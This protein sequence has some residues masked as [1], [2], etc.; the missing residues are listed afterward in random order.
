VPE[1]SNPESSASAKAANDYV[2]NLGEKNPFTGLSREQLSTIANDESGSFTT[3]EKY[4]AYRQA[5]DEEQKWR[6]EVVA[7]AMQEYEDTGKL[8]NFFKSALSHFNEL[9]I[10]EQSLYSEEYAKDLEEK[11][12]LDFNY[13]TH[14]GHGLPG[15][16]NESL[17]S[18]NK[19]PGF[20]ISKLISFPSNSLGYM[21][22]S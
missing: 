2:N 3:N 8:T 10:Q 17:A 18:L 5:Y 16:V 14:M 4:A 15:Q 12:D 6:S 13:F 21:P 7:K 20:E 19:G 1:P 9:P 22:R 11:I